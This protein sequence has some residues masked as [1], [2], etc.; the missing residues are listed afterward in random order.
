MLPQFVFICSFFNCILVF[1]LNSAENIVHFFLNDEIKNVVF[2]CGVCAM[3]LLDMCFCDL[4]KQG[5]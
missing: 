1:I 4:S 5:C 2:V 3:R